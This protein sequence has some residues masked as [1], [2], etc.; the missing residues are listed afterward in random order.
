PDQDSKPATENRLITVVGDSGEIRTVELTPATSVRLLDSGLHTDVSRY[1]QLLAS[2]RN[3][4]L[5]HLTLEDNG[6]G[7]R[8]LHVSY[9]SEVPIWKSTYRLLFTDAKSP[10]QTATL[11]GWSVV[12]NTT[13]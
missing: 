12:D 9:I 13:G 1:L 6:T 10:K 8:E 11:Q 4:G 2:T 3:Q 7:T 5:R